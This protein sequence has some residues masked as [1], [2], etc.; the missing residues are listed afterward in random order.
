MIEA[1]FFAAFVAIAVLIATVAVQE[2]FKFVQKKRAGRS[3]RKCYWKLVK[4]SASGNETVILLDPDS[5]VWHGCQAR[6]IRRINE[7]T[8]ISKDLGR[9]SNSQLPIRAG[10]APLYKRF[11]ALAYG[12]SCIVFAAEAVSEPDVLLD[13]LI[14]HEFAHL[15][16]PN[17]ID[18]GIEWEDTNDVLFKALF[19]RYPLQEPAE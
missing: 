15:I 18:H 2:G 7:L 4:L 13:L 5:D 1:A 3:G 8:A 16:T 19:S 10:V 14:I 12:E 17:S 6:I 11:R 9:F